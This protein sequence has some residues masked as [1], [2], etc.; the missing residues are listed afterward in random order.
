[1]EY[2]LAIINLKKYM[3]VPKYLNN[4]KKRELFFIF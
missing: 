2:F 1:M 4:S 3:K